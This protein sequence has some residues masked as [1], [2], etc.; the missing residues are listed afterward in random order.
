MSNFTYSDE[1][2]HFGVKGMRWGV[3]R[4]QN[5]DGTLTDEGRDH[6]KR[7]SEKGLFKS[8]RSK[9]KKQLENDEWLRKR[10]KE[11]E[12][13]IEQN[14]KYR[15][16]FKDVSKMP[17]N[18]KEERAAKIKAQDKYF[19]D[20]KKVEDAEY[21]QTLKSY[22]MDWAD[23]ALIKEYGDKKVSELTSFLSSDDYTNASDIISEFGRRTYKESGDWYHGEGVTDSFKKNREKYRKNSDE[24]SKRK[25]ELTPEYPKYQDNKYVYDSKYFETLRND[26]KL[27]ELNEKSRKLD[28]ELVDIVLKDLG[29]IPTKKARE[30]TKSLIIW[31]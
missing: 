30:A 11:V 5:E 21:V 29:Y 19:D 9:A 8:S 6:Y 16:G 7:I 10:T 18:T 17:Q 27:S 3:R 24:Y 31:D 14:Y 26:P 15:K 1:L 12:A 28:D 25:N 20:M 22:K 23:E 2:Y 13:F 4:Y